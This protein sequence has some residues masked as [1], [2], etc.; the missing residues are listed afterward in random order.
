MFIQQDVT[1]IANYKQLEKD[2]GLQKDDENIMRCRRSLKNAP[3]VYDAKYRIV[4]PKNSK[5]MELV[6]KHYH[7]LVLHNDLRETL[8]QVR[9]KFW[10]TELRNYIRRI[11]KKRVICDRHEGNLFQYSAPPDLPSYRLSDK[12]SFTY[13]SV[14][15][16]VHQ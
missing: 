9:T 15:I 3:M 11:I 6:V 8:N 5:F 16:I 4:L 1:K 14:V 2:P 7:K 10:I 13:S 12:F